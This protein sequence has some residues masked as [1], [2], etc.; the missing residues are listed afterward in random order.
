MTEISSE[1]PLEP[2]VVATRR[3]EFPVVT[4]DPRAVDFDELA[5]LRDHALA[6]LRAASLE[7][8]PA[9]VVVRYA[10]DQQLVVSYEEPPR[11]ERT[12]TAS[13]RGEPVR[14]PIDQLKDALG[15]TGLVG[16]VP[17]TYLLDVARNRSALTTT[18]ARAVTAVSGGEDARSLILALLPRDWPQRLEAQLSSAGNMRG[19]VGLVKRLVDDWVLA[20]T[21]VTDA[22]ASV[23]PRPEPTG[24]T[25]A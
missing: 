18:V 19:L 1:I 14:E 16:D 6:W 9:A 21:D 22:S 12:S 15:M 23:Q 25:S 2:R 13:D 8:N 20:A 5:V 10:H 17:W 4:G 24:A 11:V 3:Y 7:P